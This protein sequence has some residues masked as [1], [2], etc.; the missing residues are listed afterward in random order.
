MNLVRL[1]PLSLLLAGMSPI[2]WAD[3]APST[4]TT[5]EQVSVTASRTERDPQDL[6]VAISV[7]D[8]DSLDRIGHTHISELLSRAPGVWIS[9]GN[10][11][12]HL[13]AIRSGVLTG[14]GSCGAFYFAEDGIP[15][16]GPG[17]CN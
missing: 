16:R 4:S 6:S 14:A 10:G 9:R 12:E 2:L 8:Q 3:Q 17:F 13:T 15:L 11:Q 5:M 7:I 1:R